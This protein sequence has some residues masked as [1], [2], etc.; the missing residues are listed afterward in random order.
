MGSCA[1]GIRKRLVR[2][3]AS[4][5]SL[6]RLWRKPRVE[7]NFWTGLNFSP[8][9]EDPFANT[10]FRAPKF[11]ANGLKNFFQQAHITP[12][13]SGDTPRHRTAAAVHLICPSLQFLDR[14][15]TRLQVPMR[16]LGRHDQSALERDEDAL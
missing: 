13:L 12:W 15:K 4:P 11:S 2:S 9:F 6:R 1:I 8:T 14:G 5:L 16:H 7:G 10:Y 3:T